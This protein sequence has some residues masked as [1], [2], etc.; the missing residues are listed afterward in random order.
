MVSGAEL[1][2]IA[3]DYEV[4]DAQWMKI[5]GYAAQ[6]RADRLARSRAADRQKAEADRIFAAAGRID[7][8]VLAMQ[9]TL[10]GNPRKME[11]ERLGIQ[12]FLDNPLA[13]TAL[14]TVTTSGTGLFS[15]GAKLARFEQSLKNGNYPQAV[16]RLEGARPG[17]LMQW[18]QPGKA[19]II[20]QDI[21]RAKA[22]I[23]Q[24]RAA[25]LKNDQLVTAIHDAN[26]VLAKSLVK[27]AGGKG[28]DLYLNELRKV[29][30]SGAIVTI[31]EAAQQAAANG[32]WYR[33]GHKNLRALLDAAPGTIDTDE[34]RHRLSDMRDHV[35]ANIVRPAYEN[36]LLAERQSAVARTLEA[37]LQRDRKL[38]LCKAGLYGRLEPL[39]GLLRAVKSGS[40]ESEYLA[41]RAGVQQARWQNFSDVAVELQAVSAA[42]FDPDTY[43]NAHAGAGSVGVRRL[44][45]MDAALSRTTIRTV[46]SVLGQAYDFAVAGGGF[47]TRKYHG[48]GQGPSYTGPGA[49]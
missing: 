23:P 18:F 22:M 45:D 21:N 20:N 6:L 29:P 42:G 1:E 36:A 38:E 40:D 35:D 14:S 34:L 31:L 15:R 37:S 8:A 13:S 10:P 32:K 7:G 48:P 4:R 30:H 26:A 46:K 49:P 12:N 16:R 39:S 33:G 25:S 44:M 27:M 47:D 11:T 43:A 5:L 28:F 19:R 24:H 3:R 2:Q 17:V 9:A 41:K